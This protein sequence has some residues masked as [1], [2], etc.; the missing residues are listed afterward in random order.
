MNIA[1]ENTGKDSSSVMTKNSQFSQRN[2]RKAPKIAKNPFTE[3]FILAS[4]IPSQ[5]R[6][7]KIDHF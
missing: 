3:E 6:Q 1:I 5:K 7:S 4:P 2:S